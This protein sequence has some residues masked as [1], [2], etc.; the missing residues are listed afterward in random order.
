MISRFLR[1]ISLVCVAFVVVSFA[2]FARDQAAGASEHQQTELVAGANTSAAPVAI[3][4]RHSEPRRFIDGAAN[5][6]TS[7][8]SAVVKS[9]NPWV[10]HGLP[11]LF[12][13]IV[14]GV[15]LGYLARFA[16]VRVH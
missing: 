3:T 10:D 5:T 16:S 1:L 6:L 7:P 8:F 12:A 4:H 14:Y 2:M 15:G 11:A 13:L 9:S